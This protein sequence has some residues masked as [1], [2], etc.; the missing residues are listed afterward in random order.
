VDAAD[1]EGLKRRLEA[2]R[3]AF[4]RRRAPDYRD[5]MIALAKLR[6]AVRARQDELVDAV[7]SDFGGRSRQE[8]LLLELFPFYDQIRHARRH[9]RSW[10]RRRSVRNTWY[11]QPARAWYQYQP[12]GVVGVIGAWNYQLLLTLGPVVDAVAAGNHVMI[13]PSEVTPQ[14]AELIARIIADAFPPE[15][16]CCVTGGPEVAS[17]FSALPFDHLFF[18]GSA[19]VGK[20]VMHAAAQNLT[21]VTLELGGKSPALLH[22]SYPFVRAVERVITGKLYNAGQTCVAPDY[23]LLPEGRE[24][25]FEAEAARVVGKLYPRLVDNPDYT[26]IVNGR[27]YERLQALVEDAAAKG[28]RIVAVNPGSGRTGSHNRVMAPTLVFGAPQSAA[29]MQEEIFGPILPVVPY[30]TLEEAIDYVNARPRP[31]AFYYFD[32]DTRRVDRVLSSTLSGGVTV[33]DCIYHL[34]QHRLPFGGVGA[35]GMGQYHGFDGF[36]TFSK[37]RGVM[38][39]RRWSAASLVRAPYGARARR[40]IDV[41]LRLALRSR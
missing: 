30:R 21:P 31:L 7:S 39:Q 25:A 26:R 38:L 2:Q 1:A 37:K 9:L 27:H 17:T 36:E 14:S 22:E 4:H 3:A 19:R 16:L 18:T 33:N 32:E 5:R 15:Y 8:T 40:V 6:D 23:L 13:K 20:Q 41:L 24:T 12:L 29:V 10:M 34:G 11:L 35:S 28:A